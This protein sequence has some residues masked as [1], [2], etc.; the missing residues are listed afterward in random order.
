MK[1]SFGP[2]LLLSGA[3]LV[4]APALAGNTVHPRTP[5]VWPATDCIQTVEREVSPSF[6]FAYSIPREDTYLSADELSD[7]R[8]HQFIAFCRQWPAGTS[9][10][11]YITVADLQRALDNESELDQS[12]LDN[13]E[14]TLETSEEWAGCWTR[15]TADDERRP[16][17]FEAAAEP[18]VWD[19]T[20]IE[21]GTWVIAGYTWEPPR[22]LWVRAPWVVRVLDDAD[23]GDADPALAL[24]FTPQT[25]DG[26]DS[27]T[28]PA[29]VDA[30]AD[31]TLRIDWT[32]TKDDPPDWREGETIAFGGVATTE[33]DF[34]PPLEA[35]GQQLRIRA[36]VE[37]GD[38]RTYDAHTHSVVIVFAE[39][40]GSD[41]DEDEGSES[42]SGETDG[43]DPTSDT[44]P[45]LDEGSDAGDQPS[46]CDCD[47]TPERGTLPAF[48]LLALLIPLRRRLCARVS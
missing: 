17:T 6:E 9:P 20:E 31:A 29:C 18:V 48:V 30:S 24:G 15:I 16:I 28:I 47:A 8:T 45:G 42:E 1:R 37:Q 32:T 2:T 7:S 25:L 34:V 10:P 43:S 36:R 39:P 19:T 40:G 12:L 44:G 22:N 5:V 11:N 3:L 35:W 41:S 27:L 4:P 21:A 46:G 26:G 23:A 13:P 14:A 38:G 33:V